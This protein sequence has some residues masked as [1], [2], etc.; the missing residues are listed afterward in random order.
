MNTQQQTD[1]LK[2][3]LLE[4]HNAMHQGDYKHAHE[5][6]HAALGIDNQELVLTGKP[7]FQGFDQSFRT[8]L[9]KHN[10]AA[11]YIILDFTPYPGEQG[12]CRLM[13][14]GH[15]ETCGLV[16]DM[17]QAYLKAHNFTVDEKGFPAQVSG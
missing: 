10:V 12:N 8:A 11:A 17:Y 15:V 13:T 9:R 7:Y 2:Q 5:I 6:M 16:H 4:A 14:G 1:Q 3:A